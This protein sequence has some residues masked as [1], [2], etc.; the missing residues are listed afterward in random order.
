MSE[1]SG[2]AKATGTSTDGTVV[3]DLKQTWS[4][5]GL[6]YQR[7]AESGERAV[8]KQLRSNMASVC[9]AAEAFVA[10]NNI[11]TDEQRKIAANTL[12]AELTK[13]GH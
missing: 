8:V 12:V 5:W 13:W 7:F 6:A 4:D 10:I 3:V 9:A 11:L 2:N 1:Q